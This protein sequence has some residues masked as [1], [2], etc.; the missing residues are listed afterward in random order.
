M[1]GV[2]TTNS[3]FN[4]GVSL[5]NTRISFL[6]MGVPL[7]FFSLCIFRVLPRLA[8][9][10]SNASDSTISVFAKLQFFVVDKLFSRMQTV[11]QEESVVFIGMIFLTIVFER[12]DQNT[13]I[14]N[15][16]LRCRNAFLDVKG[17]VVRED[18]TLIR[19]DLCD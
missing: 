12:V 1:V 19:R 11:F 13:L 14:A 18:V 10:E 5:P 3:S 17:V 8:K 15:E 7:V 6:I 4:H 2:L 16:M 9:N